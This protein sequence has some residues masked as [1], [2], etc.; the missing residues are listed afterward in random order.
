[1]LKMFLFLIFIT[2]IRMWKSRYNDS[3]FSGIT[4][5]E[6]SRLQTKLWRT[7]I[8]S[9]HPVDALNGVV[10]LQLPDE[11]PISKAISCIYLSLMRR[12]S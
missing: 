8:Y 12:P 5:D 10:W 6:V 4:R 3:A 9:N 1:M 2:A 7:L 11:R